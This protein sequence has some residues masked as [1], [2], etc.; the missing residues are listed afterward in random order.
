MSP[1]YLPVAKAAA[2]SGAS[3]DTEPSMRPTSPGWM[4]CKRNRRRL[5]SPSS[6]LASA[7][8]CW[9]PSFTASRFVALLGLGQVQQQLLDLRIL[10][11]FGGLLVEA[12]VLEFDH[13]GAL[14]HLLDVHLADGPRG[15][16]AHE[17]LH[18]AAPDQ[19][20]EITILLLI[21]LGEPAA[22]IM[23]LFRHLHEDLGGGRVGVHEGM[24][25]PG[26]G[27]RIVVLAGDG[28]GQ[29][30]LFGEVGEAF[31]DRVSPLI[32]SLILESFQTMVQPII[33]IIPKPVLNAI[34]AG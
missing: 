28:E 11:L 6:I 14:A 34:V 29:Y 26:I 25:K 17:A 7:V 3:V 1:R 4:T 21:K 22:V 12:V 24:G 16:V 8:R 20:N 31:Q 18:V 32:R 30:F 27:A 9:K 2:K 13:F 5:A 15:L 19:R 10:A 23:F 33:R